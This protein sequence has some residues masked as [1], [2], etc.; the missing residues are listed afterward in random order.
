MT[1]PKGLEAM[2]KTPTSKKH[3]SRR[4]GH[5]GSGSKGAEAWRKFRCQALTSWRWKI[6]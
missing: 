1:N 5:T 6:T 2:T 4:G 3:L